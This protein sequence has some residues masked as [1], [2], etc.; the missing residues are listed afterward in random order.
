MVLMK[1]RVFWYAFVHWTLLQ[2]VR[3]MAQI[4][5]AVDRFTFWLGVTIGVA[6]VLF[7]ARYPTPVR[8]HPGYRRHLRHAALLCGLSTVLLGASVTSDFILVALQFRNDVTALV[9]ILSIAAEIVSVGVI[10]FLIVKAAR[11]LTRAESSL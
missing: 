10:A 2:E 11:R 1:M 8:A 9:P 6:A 7:I 4:V 3:P 5:I